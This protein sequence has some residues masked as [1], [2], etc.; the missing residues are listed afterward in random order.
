MFNRAY[1][2]IRNKDDLTREN[3]RIKEQ[4]LKENAYQESIINKIFKRISNN[5]SLFQTQQQTQAINIQEYEIKM[6]RNLPCVKG[7]GEKLCS[8]LRSHKIRSTSYTENTLPKL[9]C[10]PKDRVATEDKNKF[11][12]LHLNGLQNHIQMNT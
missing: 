6:I 2:I 8:I 10:K 7:T 12:L 3:P 11:T 9:P 4:V 1:S 5:R